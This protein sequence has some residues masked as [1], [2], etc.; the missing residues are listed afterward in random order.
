MICFLLPFTEEEINEKVQ[1]IQECGAKIQGAEETIKRL[2]GE[3]LREQVEK[4]KASH[5][6]R[7][8]FNNMTKEQ[9]DA[10]IKANKDA[11]DKYVEIAQ[12]IYDHKFKEDKTPDDPKKN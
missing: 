10:Y 4:S 3:T 11:A 12:E 8:E 9:L 5:T 7:A 1:L 2:S 6:K